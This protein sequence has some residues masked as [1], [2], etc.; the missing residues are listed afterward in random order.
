MPAA[1]MR[2]KKKDSRRALNR[3]KARKDSR[4]AL[5]RVKGLRRACEL[6]QLQGQGRYLCNML[7]NIKDGEQKTRKHGLNMH[8]HHAK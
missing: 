4:R 8:V 2:G 6:K 1:A 3:I 5:N 7:Q